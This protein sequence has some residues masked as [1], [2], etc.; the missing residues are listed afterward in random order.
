MTIAR[1]VMDA[2]MDNYVA[3]INSGDAEGVLALFAPEAVIED[4]IGSAIKTGDELA[5]WFANTVAYST[6]IT[7][8]APLRGSHAD[9]A[10]LVFDVEFTPPGSPRLRIRSADAFRFR[11]DGLIVSLRAFWGPEDLQPAFPAA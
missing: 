10:L 11:A 4:P 2:A 1:A 5:S 3:R 7:Q 8:V 9:E 6:R